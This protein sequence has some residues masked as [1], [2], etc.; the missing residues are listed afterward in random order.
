MPVV[1]RKPG[2]LFWRW[3]KDETRILCDTEIRGRVVLTGFEVNCHL[4]NPG[5]WPNEVMKAESK[6]FMGSGNKSAQ[7]LS[8]QR[9]NWETEAEID[10]EFTRKKGRWDPRKGKEPFNTSD[11]PYLRGQLQAKHKK[12]SSS[13]SWKK[14]LKNQCQVRRPN[15]WVQRWRLETR[16]TQTATLQGAFATVLQL[17]PERT[18]WTRTKYFTGNNEKPDIASSC[19][20]PE[21][22]HHSINILPS[23]K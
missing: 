22:D 10:V 14:Q 19:Y 8:H 4:V 23:F 12:E 1:K 20:P 9:W 15:F 17:W 2:Q 13:H 6:E 18:C 16:T 7:K 11:V 5:W 3:G 21:L